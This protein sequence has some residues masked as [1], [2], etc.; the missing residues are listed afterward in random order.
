MNFDYDPEQRLKRTEA[1]FYLRQKY[2]IGS[3][4]YLAKLAMIGG[5]PLYEKVRVHTTYRVQDLD[6]WA[7]GKTATPKKDVKLNA[8][9]P[10]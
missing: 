2:R 1:G 6:D 10:K 7:Q 8:E 4:S 5:G 9:G 3:P